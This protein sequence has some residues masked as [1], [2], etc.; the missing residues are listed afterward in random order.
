[1]FYTGSPQNTVRLPIELL[2]INEAR[3]I[4]KGNNIDETKIVIHAP[5]IINLA[6]SIIL[7]FVL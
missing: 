3:I 4:I 5:F 6:N 2:K 1:M 7:K